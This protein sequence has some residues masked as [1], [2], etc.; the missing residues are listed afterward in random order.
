MNLLIKRIKITI[1]TLYGLRFNGLK[2]LFQMLFKSTNKVNVSGVK[3]PIS[4]RPN[5]TDYD[6]FYQLFA[7]AEYDLPIPLNFDPQL[8]IDAGANIGL[9]AVYFKN[10]YPNATVISIEP[11]SENFEMLKKNTAPYDNVFTEEAG[12]WNKETYI[13]VEDTYGLGAH[14]M[15]VKENNDPVENS[16][17]AVTI[18]SLLEKYNLKEQ[19]IDILK[20]DIETS[21]KYFFASNYESWL[22]RT[23]LLIVELHDI[24]EKGC[25]QSFFTALCNSL[26]SFSFHMKGE[27][28]LVVN[29]GIS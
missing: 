15:I 24:I 8:I 9:A 13:T 16:L 5:T 27:N 23:R 3:Y 26:E 19:Y 18:D 28:V 7:K 11:D 2:I 25:A 12:L 10:K 20:V 6:V 29:D 22:P 21:E 1:R 14:G 4:L 17:K